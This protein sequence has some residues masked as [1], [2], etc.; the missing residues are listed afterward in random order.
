MSDRLVCAVDRVQRV[1]GDI[2]G[3]LVASER[4]RALLP[5]QHIVRTAIDVGRRRFGAS[6]ADGDG[7]RAARHLSTDPHG[8]LVGSGS[9]PDGNGGEPE[10]EGRRTTVEVRS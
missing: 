10:D 4:C 3:Q 5:N 8:R 6:S 7:Q 2:H 1:P 9:E